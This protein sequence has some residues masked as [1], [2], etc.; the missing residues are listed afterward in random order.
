MSAAP[1]SRGDGRFQPGEVRNP[2]GKNQWTYRRNFEKAVSALLSGEL[3]EAD[4]VVLPSWVKGSIHDGMS[5]GEAIAT[6]A[7]QGALRGDVKYLAELLKRVW[8]TPKQDREDDDA[9][10]VIVVRDYTGGRAGRQPHECVSPA[11][12][13]H[14]EAQGEPTL[15]CRD[16]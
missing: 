11:W 7:V 14:P 10:V 1:T 5:R 9:G 8:A 6:I 15:P 12:D 16:G 3:T 2:E 13:D 4:A